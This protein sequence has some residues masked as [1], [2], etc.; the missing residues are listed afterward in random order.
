MVWPL[1]TA[2]AEPEPTF[3][4]VLHFVSSFST[5]VSEHVGNFEAPKTM[6]LSNEMTA[7]FVANVPASPSAGLVGV[8]TLSL[9]TDFGLAGLPAFV[10]VVLTIRDCSG[11]TAEAIAT[12]PRTA[13]SDATARSMNLRIQ[14]LLRDLRRVGRVDR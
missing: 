8:S 12:T 4:P 3:D 2:V 10:F 1:K 14:I 5:C 11:L 13:A 6:F 7:V 9:P